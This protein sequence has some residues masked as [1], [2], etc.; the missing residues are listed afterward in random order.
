MDKSSCDVLAA[1][2][3]WLTASLAIT[4]ADAVHCGTEDQQQFD[5]DEAETALATAVM[6]WRE[7][8]RPI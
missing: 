3:N 2:D 5:L 6:A 7:A 4:A 1:A 8:F